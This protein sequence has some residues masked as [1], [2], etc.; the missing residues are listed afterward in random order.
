MKKLLLLSVLLVLLA[1]CGNADQEAST[2][3]AEPI[4][5]AENDSDTE[6]VEANESDEISSE[7]ASTADSEEN[8]DS[9]VDNGNDDAP[10]DNS[11]LKEQYVSELDAIAADLESKPEGETQMEMEEIASV[12]Y[13]AWDNALNKIFSDLEKQLPVEQMDKLREEQ[14]RWIKEKYKIASEEAAQYEGGSMESLAKINAQA[15]FT[16]ERCYELVEKYM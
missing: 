1:A 6:S 9:G 10:A 15:Q 14:R 5:S 7:E 3:S 11:P 2:P 13:K 16:K 8:H 12:A 4:H